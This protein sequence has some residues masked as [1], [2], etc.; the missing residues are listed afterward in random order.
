[1]PTFEIS[2]PSAGAEGSDLHP[3]I[4]SN[5]SPLLGISALWWVSGG[6][7]W[8]CI[9]PSK[10]ELGEGCQS[11][12]AEGGQQPVFNFSS[13]ANVLRDISI[14]RVAL[15]R[16]SY[17][18]FSCVFVAPFRLKAWET[19]CK[20]VKYSHMLS[21]SQYWHSV[22]TTTTKMPV[23]KDSCEN[24]RKGLISKDIG[25][26]YNIWYFQEMLFLFNGHLLCRKEIL[27]KSLKESFLFQ[28][29]S[30]TRKKKHN[31]CSRHVGL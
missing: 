2:E 19:V 11:W 15:I 6:C 10:T 28:R 23:V 14:P 29:L 30:I 4:C 7:V 22:E 1:M 3:W 25:L 21:A 13:T 24:M 27:R 8:L 26:D 16:L 20:P 9:S 5:M 18:H 31:N 17:G 12:R